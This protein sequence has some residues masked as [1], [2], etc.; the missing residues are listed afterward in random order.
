MAA[1]TRQDLIDDTIRRWAMLERTVQL[2][3]DLLAPT[4]KLAVTCKTSL[5]LAIGRMIEWLWDATITE[6]VTSL[7]ENAVANEAVLECLLNVNRLVCEASKHG[8]PRF[9]DRFAPCFQQPSPHVT[10]LLAD[11]A[12]VIACL[13][14]CVAVELQLA[15]P[16]SQL[17]VS[18]RTVRLRRREWM[19]TMEPWRPACRVDAIRHAVINC[20]T[21]SAATSTASVWARYHLSDWIGGNWGFKFI[22]KATFFNNREAVLNLERMFIEGARFVEN[23]HSA[24]HVLDPFSPLVAPNSSSSK[25]TLACG[26]VL[27]ELWDKCQELRQSLENCVVSGDFSPLQLKRCLDAARLVPSAFLEAVTKSLENTDGCSWREAATLAL[28]LSTP[29]QVTLSTTATTPCTRESKQVALSTFLRTGLDTFGKFDLTAEVA[30][31][32]VAVCQPLPSSTDT[33]VSMLDVATATVMLVQEF[34]VLSSTPQREQLLLVLLEA[35]PGISRE[36]LVAYLTNARRLFSEERRLHPTL[37]DVGSI[38]VPVE[39]AYVAS[40]IP[41]QAMYEWSTALQTADRDETLALALRNLSGAVVRLGSGAVAI[42]LGHCGVNMINVSR[43]LCDSFPFEALTTFGERHIVSSGPLCRLCRAFVDCSIVSRIEQITAT[44]VRWR[45]APNISMSKKQYCAR[46]GAPLLCFPALQ[47]SSIQRCLTEHFSKRG[48]MCRAVQVELVGLVCRK[49]AGDPRLDCVS[50]SSSIEPNHVVVSLKESVQADKADRLAGG[51]RVGAVGR[52]RW[53]ASNLFNGMLTFADLDSEHISGDEVDLVSFRLLLADALRLIAR[54]AAEAT[55]AF[56]S[57]AWFDEFEADIAKKRQ[58]LEGSIE[59]V[60]TCRMTKWDVGRTTYL[61]FMEMLGFQSLTLSDDTTSDCVASSG[62]VPALRRLLDI[63]TAFLEALGRP[64]SQTILLDREGRHM[65][66]TALFSTCVPI[67]Q[68]V[69]N[70]LLVRLPEGYTDHELYSTLIPEALANAVAGTMVLTHSHNEENICEDKVRL[71]VDEWRH[72]SPTGL[73]SVA[74]TNDS[75]PVTSIMIRV[76]ERATACARAVTTRLPLHHDNASVKAMEKDVQ[77]LTTAS[78]SDVFT[79]MDCMVSF[80][81]SYLVI[82]IDRLKVETLQGNKQA[83]LTAHLER[84]SCLGE[85]SVRM[86]KFMCENFHTF[87]RNESVLA[88]YLVSAAGFAELSLAEVSGAFRSL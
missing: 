48:R 55:R 5:L 36:R 20:C 40:C 13:E 15:E 62:L 29:L 79:W 52:R 65:T 1:V 85:A 9:S 70:W 88:A 44:Y 2:R 82:V 51:P 46:H 49:A 50:P 16:S 81:E 14:V 24:W 67:L 53:M 60:M 84:G 25:L 68:S 43:W 47:P 69:V 12:T 21:L 61:R 3:H 72:E 39:V 6:T 58:A 56:Q 26:D 86:L 31:T 78:L 28:L 41:D 7:D 11:L 77:N 30:R 42:H 87:G 32:A 45:H 57:A 75:S 4:R 37:V 27:I 18:Y 8:V 54:G 63:A 19:G 74:L 64:T 17:D 59:D 83:I 33:V 35:S 22:D 80:L 38:K 71:S 23:D 73:E 76:N 66:A 10:P 34:E